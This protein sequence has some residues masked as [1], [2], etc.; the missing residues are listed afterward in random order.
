MLKTKG[1]IWCSDTFST[2]KIICY[3]TFFYIKRMIISKTRTLLII[4]RQKKTHGFIV[5]KKSMHTRS[6]MGIFLF[7][8]YI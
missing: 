6:Y 7:Y 4:K 1:T 2:Q 3:R 5:I 8:I